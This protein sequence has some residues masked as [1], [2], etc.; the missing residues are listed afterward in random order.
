MTDQPWL[1]I[2][3]NMFAIPGLRSLDVALTSVM[4]NAHS[5][6]IQLAVVPGIFVVS[7]VASRIR[8]NP[9]PSLATFAEPR[10]HVL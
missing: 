5:L 3:P 2:A 10:E 4:G 8:P 9:S 1:R 6:R 7:V